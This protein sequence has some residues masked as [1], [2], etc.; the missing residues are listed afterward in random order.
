MP[1]RKI[2]GNAINLNRSSAS[3]MKK[4]KRAKQPPVTIISGGVIIAI[5]DACVG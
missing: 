1:K 5:K 3:I 2:A 4:H